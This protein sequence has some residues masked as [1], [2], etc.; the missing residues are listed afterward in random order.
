MFSTLIP[1]SFWMLTADYDWLVA[2]HKSFSIILTPIFNCKHFWSLIDKHRF[3]YH[4][5]K[6]PSCER[7]KLTMHCNKL[8][9]LKVAKWR[10][11]EWRMMKDE[12]RMIISSF[13]GVLQTNKLTDKRTDI[14]DCR[15]AFAT[16]KLR[17]TIFVITFELMK[18]P[19]E[20]L[21]PMWSPQK[22]LMSCR[23]KRR[24]PV[25]QRRFED[26]C[27]VRILAKFQT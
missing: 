27:Y 11:D 17:S 13:E 5:Q 20:P 4:E 7:R 26:L 18:V 9:S 10:K 14:C 21:H 15:V 22:Y 12:W 2:K 25:L 24:V 8:K 16:D 19:F 1:L 3:W 23:V 6:D